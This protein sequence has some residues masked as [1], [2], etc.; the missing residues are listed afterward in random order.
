LNETYQAF[1]QLP[2][3]QVELQKNAIMSRISQEKYNNWKQITIE[4]KDKIDN[5][6]DKQ[7]RKENIM[8]Q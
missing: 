3:Q 6:L 7:Q 5:E 1:K 2:Q 4:N 8:N